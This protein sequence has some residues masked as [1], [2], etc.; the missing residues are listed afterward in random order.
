MTSCGMR[1]VGSM[2]VDPAGDFSQ[3]APTSDAEDPDAAEPMRLKKSARQSRILAE[4]E[5]GPSLRVA[6]LAALLSVSTETIRRDL[7]ELTAIGR[8]SRTYGGAV[9]RLSSEP[10]VTERH[11]LFVPERERIARAASRL[12]KSGQVLM[13]GSGATTVHTARRIAAD[14][15]DL[16]VFTHSFGVATV[17]AGNPT[18]TIQMAPG[19]YLGAEGATV[20]VHTQ[21]FL[22]DFSADVAILGASGLTTE[23]ANDALIEA[24][25][26]YAAMIARAAA[27]IVVA[28]HSKFERI[29]PAR[30]GAWKDIGH[31][32]T[33]RPADG[34]LKA[35]LLRAGTEV[36]VAP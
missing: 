23:G 11:H 32:V 14:H 13:I 25:A 33:D 34:T 28:D 20:G 21:S 31:L 26:I 3:G 9:R 6:D 7:D 30:F 15:R 8:L 1:Y 2:A 10:N 36:V 29:F 27:T 12:V 22:A 35:A 17:M 18:I 19:T 16:V 5:E 24:A 4:L